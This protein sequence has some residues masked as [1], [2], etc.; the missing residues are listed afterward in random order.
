MDMDYDYHWQLNE[1]ATTLKVYL[2]NYRGGERVFIAD[3]VLHRRRLTRGQIVR[4][5]L[6]F[7][8]MTGQVVFAIYYEAFRL[9]M[10]KCPYFPHPKTHREVPQ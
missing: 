8:W 10:K 2:A 3:M 1:P 7:P 4:S 9:W 6:R 5:W